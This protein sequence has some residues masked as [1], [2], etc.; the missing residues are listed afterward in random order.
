[1]NPA[2]LAP[3]FSLPAINSFD[4]K[5]DLRSLFQTM[6]SKNTDTTLSLFDWGSENSIPDADSVK[7]KM[8]ALEKDLERWNFEY[9]VLDAPSVP[10]SEYDKAF[11]ELV[12]LEKVYPQ[13]KSP[14]SP[15]ERVGGAARSDLVKVRHA[16]P[17]L[18]IHTETDFEATGAKAFDERVR[19]GLGLTPADPPVEYDAE[20]KFDGLAMNLRYE[21]GVLVS[22][23]TRGDG[24]VGEDVTANVKTIRTI[25]LPDPLQDV[26][27]DA[28]TQQMQA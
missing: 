3:E 24:L 2:A 8:R 9:Y 27:V 7:A 13:F 28:Y 10:D 18:S 12:E 26:S 1:M 5:S 14:A 4:N 19:K 16:L 15:T 23:A 20:L 17:M 25:P 21:N 11:N 22:A 6:S